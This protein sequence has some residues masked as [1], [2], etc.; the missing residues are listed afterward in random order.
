MSTRVWLRRAYEQ[1]GPADG[2]RVLVDRLWP[3]GVAREAARLACWSRDVAPSDGLRRWFDHQ[4]ERWPAFRHRYLAELIHGDARPSLEALAE[5]ARRH[6]VTLVF[7]A[8]DVAH[9]HAVALRDALDAA[10]AVEFPAPRPELVG[11]FEDLRDDE[12][13]S[14]EE[15]ARKATGRPPRIA[16]DVLIQLALPAYVDACA[17]GVCHDGAAEVFAGALRDILTS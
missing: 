8:R 15:L 16:P 7:G 14:L 9:S 17:A 1:P 5:T 13:S 4:A 12:R 6:R 2:Y 10:L 11:T 3:R